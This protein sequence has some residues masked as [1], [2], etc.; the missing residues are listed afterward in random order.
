MTAAVNHI[1]AVVNHLTA[2]LNHVTAVVNHM[3]AVVYHLIAIVN[4]TTAVADHTLSAENQWSSRSRSDL[5]SISGAQRCSWLF[6]CCTEERL[7]A[8][9]V[10]GI[11][12]F[13][14][15]VE[16]SKSVVVGGCQGKVEL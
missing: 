11:R 10:S 2:A 12:A 7:G 13:L 1:A 16:D 9:Y 15:L 4:R 6:H 14:S 8:I 3:A 5:S